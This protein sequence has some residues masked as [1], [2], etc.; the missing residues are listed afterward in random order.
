MIKMWNLSKVCATFSLK[1][2]VLL[3]SAMCHPDLGAWGHLYGWVPL[4]SSNTDLKGGWDLD[5]RSIVWEMG[6]ADLWKWVGSSLHI[7]R[8]LVTGH[9]GHAGRK[10]E[11]SCPAKCISCRIANYF[12]CMVRWHEDLLDSHWL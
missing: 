8:G 7:C 10:E 3:L 4:T 9:W 11:L 1:K 6:C 5:G 12:C 2:A